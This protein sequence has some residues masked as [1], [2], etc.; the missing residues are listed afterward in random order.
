MKSFSSILKA[1]P[2]TSQSFAVLLNII[3]AR[4]V[5]LREYMR[6]RGAEMLNDTIQCFIEARMSWDKVK[7][8]T[9]R[10]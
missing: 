2:Q 5:T 8:R 10:A 3:I 9:Q 1:H 4:T 6:I 7:D